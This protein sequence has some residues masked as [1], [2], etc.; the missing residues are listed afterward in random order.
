MGN[1][2]VEREEDAGSKRG[3]AVGEIGGNFATMFN[4]SLSK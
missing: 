3:Q 2:G 1:D 4:I